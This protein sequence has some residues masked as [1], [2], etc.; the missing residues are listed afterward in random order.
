YILG[1][2]EWI[3]FRFSG[4]EPLLRIYS[5]APSNERV[6]KNLNFGRSIIK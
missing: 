2:N 1:D 6:R 4:T 5:E 3:L